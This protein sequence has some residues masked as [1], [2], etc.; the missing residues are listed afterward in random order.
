MH[1]LL[2]IYFNLCTDNNDF[3]SEKKKKKLNPCQDI[4]REN[5]V[6]KRFLSKLMGNLVPPFLAVKLGSFYYRALE[7]DRAKALQETNGIYDASLR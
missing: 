6:I 5:A 7:A 1:L 2:M 3:N 4:L